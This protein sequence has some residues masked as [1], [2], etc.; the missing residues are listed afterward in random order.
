MSD[1]NKPESPQPPAAAAPESPKTA[2]AAPKA[3][4][5][6]P[7][8]KPAAPPAPLVPTDPAPPADLAVPPYVTALQERLP[9][10]VEQV[11]YWVGDWSVIV[12]V[13][14]VVEVATFLRDAPE[15]RFDYLSDL[16][17]ADWPARADRRFDVIYCLY[18]TQARQRVR[19]KV[20]AADGQAV[21]SVTGV[22]TAANWLEREVFDM[23]GI[24]FTGHPDLR[25]ILM[26]EDWQ[27]HPQRKDY[28]LEG[29]G[30]LLME[31]P[32]DWLKARQTAVEADI[33]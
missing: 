7:A 5:A 30:E 1:D 33:E 23:F 17:A 19:V 31:S 14:R 16:T 8:A 26:P 15:G 3:A 27:G 13:D 20:R 24:P 32:Q 21:P 18:A 9:G 11:T 4:A 29:P 10:A 25:R 2:P 6:K 28:P 12:P 22:W